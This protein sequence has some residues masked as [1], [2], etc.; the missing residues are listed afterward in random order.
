MR[1]DNH[2]G[3]ATDHTPI[4]EAI[5][6]VQER[7]SSACR[8]CGRNP[9]EVTLVAVSKTV[10][11]DRIRQ[12]HDAGLRHFGENRVQ[13]AEAKRPALSDLSATWHLIGHLQTNKAKTARALFDWVHSVDSLRVAEK[14]DVAA[15][16]GGD[17][18]PVL[19][20]VN[21]AEEATKSG[22]REP[23]APALAGQISRLPRLEL[24]GLM[25]LPPFSEEA[26]QAR[27]FFR[28]LRQ[29]AR[30][31]EAIHLD[32]V[33][34]RELSMGMSQDFEVAIEEGATIVRVGTALFGP[35]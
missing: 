9:S 17:R 28:R 19:I 10:P 6:R 1:P 34:M 11:P 16:A 23:E 2:G 33:C 12:A 26:E 30:K 20:V 3:G 27:L 21:L 35:R 31:I 8:R 7:I 18:L 24:L 13:E 14:L 25:T 4:G 15:R 22:I 5:S 29:L 32:N